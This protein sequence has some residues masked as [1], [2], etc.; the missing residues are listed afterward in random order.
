MWKT[1][2]IIRIL[3]DQ[4]NHYMIILKKQ[5]PWNVFRS[6]YLYMHIDKRSYSGIDLA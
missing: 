2:D 5:K 3:S 1:L 6:G 4:I